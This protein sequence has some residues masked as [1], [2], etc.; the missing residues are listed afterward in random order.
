M[1]DGDLD[2]YVMDKDGKN[3][4][5]LTSELGYDGGAFFSPDGKQIV[6]RAFHPK[7]EAEIA[8]YRQRTRGKLN[9]A[10]RV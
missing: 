8:R 10:D 1:R 9:R 2:L 4:K 6:Y 5:R 3:V 7:T